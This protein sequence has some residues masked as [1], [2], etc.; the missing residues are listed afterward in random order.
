MDLAVAALDQSNFVP[1]IGRIF[2]QADLSGRELHAPT[3]LKGDG[4]AVAKP[5][6]RLVAGLAAN[7]DVV[8]LGNMVSGFGELLGQVAVV[9]EEQE[10]FAGVVEATDGVDALGQIAEELHDGGA[11]FGVG[12][13][14]D[15]AFRLVQQEIDESLWGL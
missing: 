1:R 9:G 5:L 13:G 14:G 4:D 7:F 15:V 2:E 6:E 12:D 11:T 8:G 3:V 10:A